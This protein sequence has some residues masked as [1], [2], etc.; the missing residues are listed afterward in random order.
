MKH[1]NLTNPQ[2]IAESTQRK[3]WLRA[4]NINQQTP[5]Q[6]NLMFKN[7][8][9][10]KANYR[11]MPN[12]L[13]RSA[14]FTVGNHRCQRKYLEKEKLF[15]YNDF[16]TILY[17]GIELRAEDDQVIWMQI[18]NYCQNVPLGFPFEF[19]LKELIKDVGWPRSGRSYGRA[20]ECISRLKANEI[21]ALNSRAYGSSGAM[22]LIQNYVVLNDTNG[23]S[24]HFHCW[25][26]PNV[27]VFFAGN[28]FTSHLWSVYI[29]LTP[30]ARRL[31]DYIVS[32]KI[33]Y[34]LDL[35]KFKQMCN[36]DNTNMT[37]W[38]Q[39]VKRACAEVEQAKIAKIARVNSADMIDFCR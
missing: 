10:D 7:T 21:L 33:P 1:N 24:T 2:Q 34:S 27:I 8:I 13:G 12:D 3:V 14:L 11:H 18:V 16:I 15:H 25:I 22:S 36:S 19:S 39:S 9:A 32:H 35:I 28:T 26:D 6:L 20:R 30:V 5:C 4:N 29:K 37:S 23:K 31:S 17:T 38:R